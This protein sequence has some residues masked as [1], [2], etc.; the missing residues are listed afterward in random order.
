M[1]TGGSQDGAQCQVPRGRGGQACAQGT[2]TVFFINKVG[3]LWGQDSGRLRRQ[4]AVS[5]ALRSQLESSGA[6]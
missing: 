1:L 3:P 5:R 4:T 6:S 2:A